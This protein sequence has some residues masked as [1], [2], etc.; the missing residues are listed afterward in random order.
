MVPDIQE[1]DIR[2]AVKVLR[3]GMLVQGKNVL[4]L[5]KSI[6]KYL[7]VKNAIVVSSGTATLH[8]ALV[9]LGIGKGDE[10]IIPAF[11]YIATAN[12][13]ELV[14]AKP[15]FVDV[16][17]DTFN[18]NVSAIKE[19]I[20][21]KT[22]AIMPVHEFGLSCNI[23]E[24]V[25]LANLHNLHVIEDAACA[26]GATENGKFAGT[27]GDVGSFSFHPRKA[28]TCG[29]GGVLT[30]NNDALA[31]ELRIIRNHGVEIVHGKMEFVAPGFNYRL[32]DFQASL[33][34]SQL[35]RF[36][37]ELDK[38]RDLA[39]VYLSNLTGVKTPVIPKEKNHT[40]Q[41]F[42]IL[43]KERDALKNYLAKNNIGSNLGAQCIPEEKYYKKKYKLDSKKLYPNAFKANVQGLVLP[44]YSQLTKKEIEKIAKIINQFVEN[45]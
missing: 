2:E 5:E 25:Q 38:K 29:E 30:T 1:K 9:A 6:E 21:S 24:I 8:L 17:I 40:W 44:L 12:V 42:H 41:S 14:G 19:K 32:T 39:S 27:F 15:V 11:S 35:K 10:V 33:A 16:E 18:I 4:E 3:S 31:R 34:I 26:F 28:I 13:I 36:N 22:K 23:S 45:I 37:V 20:S 43:I 7:N